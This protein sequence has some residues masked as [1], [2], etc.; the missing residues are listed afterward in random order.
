MMGTFNFKRTFLLVTITMIMSSLSAQQQLLKLTKSYYRSDPFKT[1]FGAFVSHLIND[2]D[3]DSKIMEKKTDTSLFYFSGKYKTFN[4]FFSKP[5]HLEI[6]LQEVSMQ[7]IDSLP[8]DT[9]YIYQLA[10]VMDD[11]EKGRKEIKKEFERVHKLAK[12]QFVSNN[13]KENPDGMIG[14]I[15]NY[16]LPY[17]ELAPFS[18]IRYNEQGKLYLLLIMRIKSIEN[19]SRLPFG[20]LNQHRYN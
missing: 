12:N 14:E 18:L 2:P 5:N 13:H 4:P 17:H 16:F 3:I 11:D 8:L 19:E 10:V 7:I 15:Y 9:F 1:S 20:I 6:V